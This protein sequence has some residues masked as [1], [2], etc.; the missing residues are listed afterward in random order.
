MFRLVVMASSIL[1]LPIVFPTPSARA[2]VE[3]AT[4]RVDG[5]ACPFCAYG[6]EKKLKQIP[7]HRSLEV[8][9]NEGKI[10]VGWR[11]DRPLDIDALYGAVKDAGFTLRT[12]EATITGVVER[13]NGR[14]LLVLPAELD[15]R[16]YLY[17]RKRAGDTATS[18]QSEGRADSLSVAM[19]KRLDDI[20]AARATV[21][22]VGL[23]HSHGSAKRPLGLE[24]QSVTEPS[25]P[26]RA[27]KN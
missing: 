23:V 18:H 21:R 20:E 19:R 14:Y 2:Q 4:L 17:E 5:L 15:Q 9:I 13:Q 24:I 8:L 26:P 6:V 7:G 27:D 25:E 11:V 22:I 1:V 3:Q 10:I 12:I 16:F